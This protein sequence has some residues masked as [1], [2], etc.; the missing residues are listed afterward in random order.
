MILLAKVQIQILS[1]ILLLSMTF[2]DIPWNWLFLKIYTVR[3]IR[4][5]KTLISPLAQKKVDFAFISFDL[6][7]GSKHCQVSIPIKMRY[8]YKAVFCNIEENDSSC[9]AQFDRNGQYFSIHHGFWN[10]DGQN[11]GGVIIGKSVVHTVSSHVKLVPAVQGHV[12]KCELWP[13]VID[14]NSTCRLYVFWIQGTGRPVYKYN[15]NQNEE[16]QL[17]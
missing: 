9:P 4:Y 14:W 8:L 10:T 16:F 7:E 6:Y 5:E 15:A 2:G 1:G 17:I 13:N 12:G 3:H 11:Q